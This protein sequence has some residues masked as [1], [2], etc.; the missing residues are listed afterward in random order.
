MYRQQALG[1][2]LDPAAGKANET[3]SQ[4]GDVTGHL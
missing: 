2:N 3:G 4:L 1:A